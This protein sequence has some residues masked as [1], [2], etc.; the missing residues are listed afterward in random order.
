MNKYLR[1]SSASFSIVLS[2]SILVTACSISPAET[3]TS[4][5][6]SPHTTTPSQ[7]SE[8]LSSFEIDVQPDQL[9]GFS[10]AGQRCIFLVTLIDEA[11]T[12]T[13]T[14]EISAT[15]NDADVMI[16]QKLIKDNQ[17][18]EVTVI[19]NPS[20]TGKLIEVAITGTRGAVQ[21]KKTVNFEVIEGADDRKEYAV[22]LRDTF[23]EWLDRNHPELN[24]KSDAEWIGTMVSPQWLVV[25]HYLFFSD[26][27]EMHVEWHIMIAPDDWAHIDLR[28][29]FDETKPSYAFEIS[30]RAGNTEPKPIT[31][32]ETIWR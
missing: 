27:W 16:E 7:T 32:P 21:V 14:V 30:S 17:V 11:K 8:T 23:V 24:L 15:A 28:H 19:P 25:S 20:S 9:K 29:R 18:A 26:E 2:L 4:R 22:V 5:T 3:E 1:F 13:A 10:L 31:V 6:T 12:G